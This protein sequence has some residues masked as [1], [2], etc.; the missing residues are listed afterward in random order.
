MPL[1]VP[2]SSVVSF[3]IEAAAARSSALLNEPVRRLPERPRIV[4][5][6]SLR[7]L[8]VRELRVYTDVARELATGNR[9]DRRESAANRPTARRARRPPRGR[10]SRARI[11]PAPCVRAGAAT[12]R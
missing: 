8:F 2:I 4:V 5:I 9:R 1:I 3:G 12:D 6:L 11:V 7:E 10:A